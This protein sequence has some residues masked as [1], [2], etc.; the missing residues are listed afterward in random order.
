[1]NILVFGASGNTGK[2]LV[3]KA[4]AEGYLVT[5]FLR[6]T[7][8]MKFSNEHLKIVQGN[9][10]DYALVEQAMDNQDAVIS[11]LG[12]S[13]PLKKDPIVIEGIKNIIKAME[14]K[15]IKRLVY[16]S[17]IGVSESRK[18][19]G[20]MIKHII[21]RIVHN[22]IEDHEEKESLIKTSNLEWTIVRPP[23]LKNGLQKGTYRYGE[24]IKTSSFFPIMT[25]SDVADFILKQL[26]DN[27][28]LR[29]VARVMY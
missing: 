17:F 4:L 2:D 7:A 16:L 18:D 22:E 10:K 29:K 15:N 5:A 14:V 23:K 12:V 13:K 21:S 8:K 20:F 9:V 3:K 28:F 19:S 11:V 24:D 6:S 25:R 27:T 26:S 1:M